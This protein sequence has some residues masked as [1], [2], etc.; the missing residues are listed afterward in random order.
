MNL[1]STRFIDA[2]NLAMS[3]HKIGW[4]AAWN[5][6]RL[7]HSAIYQRMVD[8]GRPTS[9]RRLCAGQAA[10][11]EGAPRRAA[12]SKKFADLVR[13]HQKRTGQDWNTSW[14]ACSQLHAHVANEMSL[15]AHLEMSADGQRLLDE[16]PVP[17]V[18]LGKMG[19]PQNV[20]REQFRVWKAADRAV[21]APD[22]AARFIVELTRHGQLSNGQGF[23]EIL[24]YLEKNAPDLHQAALQAA[25]QQ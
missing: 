15:P 24:A 5:R 16:W 12:A 17:P 23:D 21:I 4:D 10:V 8:E 6:T 22:I 13:D 1:A 19:L 11:N 20:S 9:Q 2:V 7:T 3:T 25:R 14:A 18:V